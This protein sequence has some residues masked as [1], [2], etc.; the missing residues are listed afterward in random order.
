MWSQFSIGSVAPEQQSLHGESLLTCQH[1]LPQQQHDTYAHTYYSP[2][3]THTHKHAPVSAWVFSGE[4]PN[5][6]TS[7]TPPTHTSH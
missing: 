2:P 1:T 3:H 4:P 5:P 6:P 7:H